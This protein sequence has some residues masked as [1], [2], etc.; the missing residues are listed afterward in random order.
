MSNYEVSSVVCF[1]VLCLC[2]IPSSLSHPT[3]STRGPKGC[4][5]GRCFVSPSVH[6]MLSTMGVVGNYEYHRAERMYDRAWFVS[7]YDMLS[8]MGVLSLETMKWLLH[9]SKASCI[10]LRSEEFAIRYTNKYQ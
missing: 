5:I 1:C 2:F 3:L 7:V 8:T 10:E 9:Q 6:D 4:T